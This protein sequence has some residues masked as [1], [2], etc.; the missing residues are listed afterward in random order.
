MRE[1]DRFSSCDDGKHNVLHSDICTW[2]SEEGMREGGKKEGG[3]TC[4]NIMT[5][6]TVLG[7]FFYLEK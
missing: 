1:R 3:E 4:I 2:G 7:L 6:F 5:G